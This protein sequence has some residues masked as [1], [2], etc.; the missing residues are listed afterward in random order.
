[1][2]K[3]V[4]EEVLSFSRSIRLLLERRAAEHELAR[5]QERSRLR[6]TDYIEF[7]GAAR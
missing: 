1:M 6:D 4:S 7:K 2:S 3:Q 5:Q